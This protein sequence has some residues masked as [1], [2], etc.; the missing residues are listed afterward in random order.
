[1]IQSRFARDNN[2]LKLV[3]FMKIFVVRGLCDKW[4]IFKSVLR[5]FKFEHKTETE[6]TDGG[7]LPFSSVLKSNSIE[8]IDNET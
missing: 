7:G 1:M 6:Q 2:Q 8:G 5:L 4:V 3:G